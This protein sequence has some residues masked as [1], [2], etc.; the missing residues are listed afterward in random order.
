MDGTKVE[1]SAKID[2]GRQVNGGVQFDICGANGAAKVSANGLNQGA[3]RSTD[4]LL[5][6]RAAQQ[7]QNGQ[8]VIV[9]APAPV[10]VAP[11]TPPAAKP[12]GG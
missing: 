8:P 10:I 9:P 3:D 12:P 6:L 2:S 5:L 1:C 11:I 4:P 7:L